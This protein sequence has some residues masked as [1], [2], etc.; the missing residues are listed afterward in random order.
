MRRSIGCP[1]ARSGKMVQ[2]LVCWLFGHKTVYKAAVG[3]TITIDTC[4]EKGTV[5]PLMRLERSRFC[6]R[7]GKTVHIG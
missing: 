3:T 4:F 1:K 6:L 2:K 7:C 5:V